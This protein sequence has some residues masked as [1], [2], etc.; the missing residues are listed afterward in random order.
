VKEDVAQFSCHTD[1]RTILRDR[2]L[3]T[4]ANAAPED[5]SGVHVLEVKISKD[6]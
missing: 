5:G 2:L 3:E 4:L 6:E 1:A